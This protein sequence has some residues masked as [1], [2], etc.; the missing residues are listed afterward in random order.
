MSVSCQRVRG[1][2]K[3]DED[4]KCDWT[5]RYRV[6]HPSDPW[7]LSFAC[8]RDLTAVVEALGGDVRVTR[9]L[10]GEP[11]PEPRPPETSAFPKHSRV[12]GQP[13]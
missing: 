12:M 3:R 10:P 8:E 9:L 13:L 2:N 7:P 6:S 1:R 4:V 5:A 11:Q